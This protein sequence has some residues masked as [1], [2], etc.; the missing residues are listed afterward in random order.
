MEFAREHYVFFIVNGK[1]QTFIVTNTNAIEQLRNMY[2]TMYNTL[3]EARQMAE[4]LNEEP[5]IKAKHYT[6]EE[7][8]QLDK[9][10]REW[11]LSQLT[12]EEKATIR[13]QRKSIDELQME[14]AREMMRKENGYGNNNGND[15]GSIRR[16]EK[17]TVKRNHNV[18][19]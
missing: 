11:G 14:F 7:R 1:A 8:R 5:I 17:R 13:E 12:E 16:S 18:W 9:L 3:P 15:Y 2:G 4:Q 10:Q 19:R 6:D